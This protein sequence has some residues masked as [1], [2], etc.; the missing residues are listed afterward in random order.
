[1]QFN[2]GTVGGVEVVVISCE[3][4]VVGCKVVV[5]VSSRVVLHNKN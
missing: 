3:D 4:V 1:M 5:V 2:V